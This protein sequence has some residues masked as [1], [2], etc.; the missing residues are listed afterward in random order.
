MHKIYKVAPALFLMVLFLAG[1]AGS[2]KAT[3]P[4]PLAGAWEYSLDTPQG[5]YTGIMKFE[6]TDGVLSGTITS[7]DQPDQAAPLMDLAFNAE[8]SEVSFKFDGGEYG[9]MRVQSMLDGDAL[10]GT[11]NVGAYNVDVPLTASKKMP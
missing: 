10:K 1:C 11:M 7:D 5:V 3:A 2:K 4:H 6:E 8:M 9:N